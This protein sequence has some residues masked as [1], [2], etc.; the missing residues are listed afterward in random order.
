MWYH[1]V[2]VENKLY[3]DGKEVSK[4]KIKGVILDFTGDILWLK[5]VK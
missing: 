2:K 3:Q 1:L 4:F 5:V